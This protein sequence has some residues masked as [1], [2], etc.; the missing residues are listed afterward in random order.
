M[1]DT[2]RSSLTHP[3]SYYIGAAVL[4]LVGV[5]IGLGLSANLDPRRVAP[6]Q[7]NELAAA[8][9]TS[10][11]LQSPF[12]AVV[13]RALPAVVYIEVKKKTGGAD[14]SDPQEELFR[15]FFG[16]GMRQ[17]R[18][19]PSSGS[20]FI[21]D[22]DG[23]VLTNNH[24]VRDANEIT[25]TLNDHRSFKAKVVGTDQETD[26]AVIKIEGDNLP[27]LPIGD[28]D[29]LR[30]GD[31]AVA[32]GNP[33]GQ[34][35][36]SVT[37]GIISAQGRSDL[38][39]WGGTPAYQDFIQTDA[40]IN[41][42]NSG[43][44]LCNIRGQAI[45]INTAINPSGQ[46]IGFA[47][48]INLARHVAEQLITHGQVTRAWMGIQPTELT[49]ELAEGFGIR[50]SKG[51][52]VQNVVE[53]TPAEKA[54]LRRNDVILEFDGQPVS[55][56]TK[57][58]LR[59]ADTP[60]G[61]EVPVVVLRD[62]K[63]F[64]AKVKLSER[65]E[66]AVAQGQPRRGEPKAVETV[67]GLKVTDLSD[68]DRA[69]SGIRSGVVVTDVADGSAADDAGIRQGDIIEE[70]GG[71]SV[72]SAAAFMKTLGDMKASRKH[73]VLLVNTSGQSRFVAL[74]LE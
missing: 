14:S 52:L 63:R 39:I 19:T 22:T 15:R 29:E 21:I 74:S 69:N 67:A 26:V 43:G 20:G 23:H 54:G 58:R 11:D 34:L 30:V 57:F 42:G 7:K 41:F 44:P 31:W 61:K 35:R 71:K 8:P 50:G 53:N 51:I 62:G 40:S 4:I 10:S 59:V 9:A 1:N 25:V 3:R 28:S 45:G 13:E 65:T 72:A 27:T 73:A 36:G 56:V 24:V 32:I 46:G 60:V 37:V 38:N 68:E 5:V 16:E 66:Q 49:P 6:F 17:P 55:D 33:L 47:I 12:V 48:P 18:I 70:V 2:N 64:T